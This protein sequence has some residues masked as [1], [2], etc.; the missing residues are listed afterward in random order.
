MPVGPAGGGEDKQENS[1]S[2]VPT[3]LIALSAS[4]SSAGLLSKSIKEDDLMLQE[5]LRA[6]SS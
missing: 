5:F 4:P 1:P 2:L 3:P 6:W